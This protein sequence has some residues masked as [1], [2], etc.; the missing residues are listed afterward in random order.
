MFGPKAP[1]PAATAAP[2]VAEPAAAGAAKPGADGKPADKPLEA[3]EKPDDLTKPP[4]GLTPKAAE[5]FQALANSNKELTG[6]LET[7]SRQVE[8]IKTTFHQNAVRPEQ[9]EQAA[10]LIGLINKG[11]HEG[12]LKILDEQRRLLSLAMGKPLPGV[13]ALAEFPDLRA[14]VDGMQMTEANALELAKHRSAGK[15]A[16][17]QAT[18]QTEA[19]ARQERTTKSVE[20]GT[21]AVDT[22][23]NEMMSSDIDYAAIEAKL[24]PE[25]KGGLLEG[26]PPQQWRSIVEKTYKLLKN[27]MGKGQAAPQIQALR[28]TGTESPKQAPKSMHEAMWGSAAKA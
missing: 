6:Q 18:M 22:F 23:C 26:V 28:P 7:A 13:D 27:N 1:P 10:G 11:D 24:L 4:E 5:R 19:T 17:R 9:F 15:Q 20:A 12:A 8:Y 14:A 21:K 2:V 25:I 3:K 16:E